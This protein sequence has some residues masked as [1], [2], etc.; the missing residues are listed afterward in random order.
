M[1]R[2]WAWEGGFARWGDGDGDG[3]EE[4]EDWVEGVEGVEDREGEEWV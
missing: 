1:L 4:G 3:G 2:M